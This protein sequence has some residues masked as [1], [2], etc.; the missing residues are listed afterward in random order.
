MLDEALQR[1]QEMVDFAPDV[2]IIGCGIAESIVHPPRRVQDFIER[3]APSG[4]HGVA[5]LQPRPYFSTSS[6][7]RRTR[8]RVTSWA[9][10]RVKTAT[11]KFGARQRMDPA[12]FRQHFDLLLTSLRPLGACVVVVGAW[13]TDDRL[14]PGTNDAFRALDVT[15]A[16]S[17]AAQGALLIDPRLCLRIWDDYLEDHMHWNDAGHERVAAQVVSA[18]RTAGPS[19]RRTAGGE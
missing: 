12:E 13:E 4:W 19:S 1:V 17:I 14:F 5:G 3:F 11:M 9:K 15:L 16:E 7:R 6:W 18:V 8:Q 10:V 2:V